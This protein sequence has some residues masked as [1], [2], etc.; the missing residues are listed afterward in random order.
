MPGLLDFQIRRFGICQ[1]LTKFKWMKIHV[2]LHIYLGSIM[3][4]G[5]LGFFGGGGEWD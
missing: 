4:E 5:V 2:I 3:G 1:R